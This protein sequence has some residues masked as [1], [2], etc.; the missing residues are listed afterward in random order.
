MRLQA[1]LPSIIND[2]QKQLL[3]KYIAIDFE[4]AFDSLN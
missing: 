3:G 4:K 2:D 1:V